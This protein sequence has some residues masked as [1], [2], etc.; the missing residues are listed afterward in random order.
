MGKKSKYGN[1]EKLDINTKIL[2][3]KKKKGGG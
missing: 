3:A 2:K 1:T